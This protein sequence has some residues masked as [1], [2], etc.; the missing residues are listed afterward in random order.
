MAGISV[1][2]S[3]L[4]VEFANRQ[5]ES[6]MRTRDAVLSASCVRLRPILMT[7]IA[8]LVGL[9][10]LAVHLHP[11]DEM[12]LPLARAVI[13]GLAGSTLL[14][15]FVVPMLYTLLKPKRERGLAVDPMLMPP[16]GPPPSDPAAT[17]AAH[18]PVSDW[19]GSAFPP[20][21]EEEG[22]GPAEQKPSGPPEEGE[23]DRT[24]GPAEGG[25]R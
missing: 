1:S 12:N 20:H 19:G 13:G 16:E 11:G 6:G 14:T 23:K 25:E 5:R 7:T 3:V 8:T 10:P 24:D 21:T 9:A 2:N 18:L 15:L 17:F 22:P 4:V